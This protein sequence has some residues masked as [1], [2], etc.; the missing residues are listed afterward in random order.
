MLAPCKA[1]VAGRIVGAIKALGFLLLARAGSICSH[2]L[3]VRSSAV[4]DST[5]LSIRI[6]HIYISRVAGFVGMP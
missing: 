4:V 6:V 5:S 2:T 3:V 1:Q